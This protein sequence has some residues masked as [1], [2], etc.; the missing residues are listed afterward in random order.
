[1]WSGDAA[2]CSAP[3]RTFTEIRA[4][5]KR[6]S[7]EALLSL[8]A[9]SAVLPFKTSSYI[10]EQLID[11]DRAPDDP[12]F[13]MAFPQPGQLPEDDF[14]LIRRLIADDV[15]ASLIAA[16]GRNIRKGLVHLE[17]KGP[18]CVPTLNG[19]TLPGLWH[20]FRETLMAF[21]APAQTCF[22]FCSYCYRW[23]RYVGEGYPFDYCDVH[24]PVPYLRQ[25]AEISDVLFTGGDPLIMSADV[26]CRFIDPI[27]DVE[28]VNT[29]RLST[30]ALSWQPQRFIDEP[31]SDA[32]LGLFEYI[33]GR[34]KHLSIMSH[35]SHP[36]E[37]ST[38][39]AEKAI[40]RVLGTGATIRCQGPLMRHINDDAA[41]L[42]ELW[43]RE[44]ALGMVPYYLFL[45]SE[46][47]PMEYFKLPLV[48]ALDIF[49]EAFRHVSGCGRTVRGPILFDSRDK[50]LLS[51]ICEINHQQVMVLKYVQAADSEKVGKLIFAAYD[52]EATRFEQLKS[53]LM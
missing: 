53:V 48:T 12:V 36:R 32:L 39:L 17:T 5:E 44:V 34:G 40:A 46:A 42:K 31:D 8:K 52:D 7:K 49:Q 28:S 30:R 16:T 27:L 14:A 37:L 15:P 24:A 43:N 6:L 47:G 9:V 50:L 35:V 13:Q 11:W 51:D 1:M 18:V 21:P 25:H 20:Q 38:P 19:K 4:L 10:I 3:V 29:I 22:A 45:D 33:V 41:V 2:V 26:L 23:M